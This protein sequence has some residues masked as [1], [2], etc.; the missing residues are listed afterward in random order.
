MRPAKR[1]TAASGLDDGARRGGGAKRARTTSADVR[2][3]AY[4]WYDATDLAARC[5][6][7]TD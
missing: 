4:G 6:S 1:K 5:L 2:A 7:T 3:P